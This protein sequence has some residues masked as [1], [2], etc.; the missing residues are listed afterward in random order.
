MGL[1]NERARDA[2]GYDKERNQPAEDQFWTW[3]I[4]CASDPLYDVEV[5]TS[6]EIP[7]KTWYQEGRKWKSLRDVVVGNTVLRELTIPLEKEAFTVD[8]K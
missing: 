4:Q 7:K 6:L 3:T 1:K 2:D 5:S 8:F